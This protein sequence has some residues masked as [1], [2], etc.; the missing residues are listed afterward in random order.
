MTVDMAVPNMMRLLV[1][2]DMVRKLFAVEE[3]MLTRPQ[4]DIPKIHYQADGLY[5]REI[6]IPAGTFVI[7][8]LHRFSQINFLMKGEIWVTTDNGM[9]KIKA[10]KVI[11]SPAGTKRAGYA[12]T[13]ATWITVVATEETNVDNMDDVLTIGTYQE[14]IETVEEKRLCHS[15][16]LD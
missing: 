1:D 8:K 11:V 15:L 4:V 7:G 2:G 6:T 14:F 10:P 16:R 5:G 12:V 9:E 3:A 13:D